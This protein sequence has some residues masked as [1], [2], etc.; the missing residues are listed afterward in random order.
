MNQ[1]ELEYKRDLIGQMRVRGWHVQ[2]HEDKQALFI[3]DISAARAGIEVWVEVKYRDKL[4]PTLHSMKHWTAGQQDWL[5]RRG[6][7]GNGH[8]FLL[9]GVPGRHSLWRWTELTIARHRPTDRALVLCFHSATTV[10]GLVCAL[11]NG[12]R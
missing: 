5:E 2:E 11:Y 7:A 6:A 10:D 8:C 3:P 9:L 1:K 4:P 12:L